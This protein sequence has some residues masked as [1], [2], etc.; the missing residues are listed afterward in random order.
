MSQRHQYTD[1]HQARLHSS[2]SFMLMNLWTGL[3]LFFAMRG[4]WLG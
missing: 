2:T 3:L 4:Y 1:A